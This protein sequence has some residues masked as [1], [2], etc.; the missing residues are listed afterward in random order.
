MGGWTRLWIVLSIIIGGAIVAV[1]DVAPPQTEQVYVSDVDSLSQFGIEN[2]EAVVASIKRRCPGGKATVAV[3]DR[4]DVSVT[5]H[6]VPTFDW[7]DAYKALALTALII[8]APLWLLG[9]IRD[10][11]R[12][13][14]KTQL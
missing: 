8:G 3:A 4:Y 13:N 7:R 2:H 11:F 6:L 5:C 14:K 12:A 10:G 9:W 1:N